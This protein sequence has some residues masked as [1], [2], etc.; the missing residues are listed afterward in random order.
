MKNSIVIVALVAALTLG[1]YVT[2]GGQAGGAAT[3]TKVAVVNLQDVINQCA[4]QAAFLAEGKA[5]AES[6]K[7]EQQQRQQQIATIST[8]LDT[9]QVGGDA[10]N[11]KREELQQKTLEMQVWVQMQ[12]QNG[13]L[14]Q[15][16]QFAEIY[17]AANE[18]SAAIAQAAGYDVVLQGG[19]L[20]DLMRLNIQQ[21]QTVVQTRKVIY[22]GD[23]VDI[24][25]AVLQRMNADFDQR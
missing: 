4:Q 19:E 8:T 16:R 24:T 6:L 21:L 13:Q 10:W 3:P 25:N 2:A 9:L 18:A 15:A 12:E 14:D 11:K 1:L 7:A 17:I 23:A 5:K 20:P 22:S